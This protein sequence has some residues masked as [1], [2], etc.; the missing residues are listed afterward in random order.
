MTNYELSW[1]AVGAGRELL[2]A[3]AG[4]PIAAIFQN[5]ATSPQLND[6]TDPRDIRWRQ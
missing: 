2:A 6:W 4:H 1:R 5:F 3:I